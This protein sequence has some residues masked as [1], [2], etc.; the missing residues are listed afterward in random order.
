MGGIPDEGMEEINRFNQA[1]KQILAIDEFEEF[2]EHFDFRGLFGCGMLLLYGTLGMLI[3]T[4]RVRRE[5]IP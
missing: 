4:L 3:T 2:F 5:M 1:L